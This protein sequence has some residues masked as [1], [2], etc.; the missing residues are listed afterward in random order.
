MICQVSCSKFWDQ[1]P[2][3]TCA[4]AIGNL[5]S[6][7]SG[8]N[9]FISFSCA[10]SPIRNISLLTPFK[11]FCLPLRSL[12][13]FSQVSTFFLFSFRFYGLVFSLKLS[14]PTFRF[15]CPSKVSFS[16][17]TPLSIY[18]PKDPIVLNFWNS[19]VLFFFLLP[20]L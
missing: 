17:R 8:V 15:I 9:I 19:Y 12:L 4:R 5:S 14:I 1:L 16:V 3:S 7:C 6:I 10:C 13:L 20:V 11:T 18:L 2:V